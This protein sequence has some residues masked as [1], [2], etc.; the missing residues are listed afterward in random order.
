MGS[1]RV[2]MM[3][4]EPGDK[5]KSLFSVRSSRTPVNR[6]LLIVI[7]A[8][9][10]TAARRIPEPDMRCLYFMAFSVGLAGIDNHDV[11]IQ[12]EGDK[13]DV[14]NHIA[15]VDHAFVD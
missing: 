10:R 2:V 9:A 1:S 14:I 4:T 3:L 13:Y 5:V 7:N 6:L 11:G 8:T 12:P 15:Q